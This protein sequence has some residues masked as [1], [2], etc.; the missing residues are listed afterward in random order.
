M[1]VVVISNRYLPS[2]LAESQR[3]EVFV[4]ESSGT[5][6]APRRSRISSGLGLN[7][8]LAKFIAR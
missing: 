6:D 2:D 4:A 7:L 8:G 5:S 1:V 3:L